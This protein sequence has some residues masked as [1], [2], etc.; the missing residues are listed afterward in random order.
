MLKPKQGGKDMKKLI[1]IPAGLIAGLLITSTS[2]TQSTPQAP[3]PPEKKI[4]TQQ[5]MEQEQQNEEE[6]MH[7][8]QNREQPPMGCGSCSS[9]NYEESSSHVDEKQDESVTSLSA[10]AKEE[11]SSLIFEQSIEAKPVLENTK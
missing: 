9:S 1:A 10:P 11:K 3:T 5:P 7:E 8:E 6:M 2:C 4:H